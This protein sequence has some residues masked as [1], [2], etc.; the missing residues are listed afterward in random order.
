MAGLLFNFDFVHQKTNGLKGA[1]E[2]L[3]DEQSHLVAVTEEISHKISYYNQ[4]E[5]ISKILN[6]PGDK[7]VQEPEFA[8]MLQNLDQCL[9]FVTEHPEYKDS[10]LYKMRYRQWY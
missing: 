4:L 2:A 9:S 3:L 1:C 10:D 6:M 7:L 8:P 5:H